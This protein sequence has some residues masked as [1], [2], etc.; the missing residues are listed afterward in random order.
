M[1]SNSVVTNLPETDKIIPVT[2]DDAI[3][4][5]SMMVSKDFKVFPPKYQ[6]FSISRNR[7]NPYKPVISTKIELKVLN[8]NL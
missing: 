2:Q 1:S 3:I 7:L 5:I 4:I 6:S 8:L